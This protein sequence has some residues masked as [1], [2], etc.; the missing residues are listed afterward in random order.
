MKKN[1][2]DIRRDEIREEGLQLT[3]GGSLRPVEFCYWCSASRPKG[4]MNKAV[5]PIR[6]GPDAEPTHNIC[7][8]CEEQK[9]N[10]NRGRCQWCGVLKPLL[11]TENDSMTT[12]WVDTGIGHLLLCGTCKDNMSEVD[13]DNP[14]Y[15][16]K[17]PLT[18]HDL[19]LLRRYWKYSD[20]KKRTK[21]P[22]LRR[23]IDE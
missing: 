11:R 6:D 16:K 13:L 10:L 15:S 20:W 8:A 2:Y 1:Q 23:S 4:E 12:T 9:A 19:E 7:A 3:S 17:V 22:V 5:D 21:P 18:D 14:K